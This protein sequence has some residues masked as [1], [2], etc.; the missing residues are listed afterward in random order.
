[1]RDIKSGSFQMR[2][3]LQEGGEES[4]DLREQLLIGLLRLLSIECHQRDELSLQ[5]GD[6]LLRVMDPEECEGSQQRDDEEEERT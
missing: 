5:R 4:F 1:L 6:G 2:R 3:E